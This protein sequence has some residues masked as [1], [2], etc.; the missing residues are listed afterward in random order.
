MHWKKE[1]R[2]GMAALTA[3]NAQGGK[4]DVCLVAPNETQTLI[5]RG[6]QGDLRARRLMLSLAQWMKMVSEAAKENQWTGCVGCGARIGD[7]GVCGWV[8]ML[9]VDE[10][11]IGMVGAFCHKCFGP[12][13]AEKALKLLEGYGEVHSVH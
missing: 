6:H 10:G 9:P 11:R 8:V 1:Y 13:A 5:L 7:H 12:D 2:E 4:F 3:E